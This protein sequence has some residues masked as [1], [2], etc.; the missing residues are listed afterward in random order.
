MKITRS[1]KCSLKFST[2]KKK[3]Q[4]NMIL[5]EYGCVVNTFIDYFWENGAVSKAELLKPIVDVPNKTWLSARLRKVAAREALDMISS[6]KEVFL[7]NK[8][9]S[10]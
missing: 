8:N 7:F 10:K 2:N 1:T 4:I 9:V 5:L 3:E 6:V